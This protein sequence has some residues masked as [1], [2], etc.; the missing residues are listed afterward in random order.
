MHTCKS[1]TRILCCDAFGGEFKRTIYWY[2]NWFDK[3]Y[4]ISKKPSTIPALLETRNAVASI[5]R[6][7]AQYLPHVSAAYTSNAISCVSKYM[8]QGCWIMSIGSE[9]LQGHFKYWQ[10]L[11]ASAANIWNVQWRL[12]RRIPFYWNHFIWY[13]NPYRI[14]IECQCSIHKPALCLFRIRKQSYSFE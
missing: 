5:G 10:S 6:Q 8:W 12:R 13:T 3:R 14:Y 2:S 11:Q 4:T 1:Q 9:Y 7:Y